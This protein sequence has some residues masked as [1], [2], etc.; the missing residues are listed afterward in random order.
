MIS[1]EQIEKPRGSAFTV[2]ANQSNCKGSANN[3]Q[4][5]GDQNMPESMFYI[6]LEWVNV[7]PF[8]TSQG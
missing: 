6:F 3:R 1:F 7:Y 2:Q 8:C 5:I 4:S